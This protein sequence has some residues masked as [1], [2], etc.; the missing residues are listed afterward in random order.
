MCELAVASLPLA[1]ELREEKYQREFH[2]LRRFRD[3]GSQPE[4]SA[5]AALYQTEM[6]HVEQHQHHERP[7]EERYRDSPQTRQ[8]KLRQQHQEYETHRD[9]REMKFEKVERVAALLDSRKEGVVNT[10]RQPSNKK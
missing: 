3:D 1:Q 7:D 4:P 2:Q 8:R 9:V 10:H 5:R 6:R